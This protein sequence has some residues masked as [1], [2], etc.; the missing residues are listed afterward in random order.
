MRQLFLHANQSSRVEFVFVSDWMRSIAERDVGVKLRHY[1]V[2]PNFVNSE[3]FRYHPKPPELRRRVLLIRSFNTAKYANDW[4]VEAIHA[5]AHRYSGFAEMQFTIVGDG[6]LWTRLTSRLTYSNVS[7]IN[8]ML[9]RDEIK[10]LHDK[11]GVF[12]CPT[13]QDAQGVSMC[14]AMASG[15]VPVSSDNT[16]IP[17]FLSKEE[18]YLCKSPAEMAAALEELAEQKDV[19]ARKSRA[20]AVRAT[21]QIGMAA[22]ISREI[23]LIRRHLPDHGQQ[24][25]KG[26]VHSFSAAVH[27]SPEH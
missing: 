5:L 11:H 25:E 10:A 4:A 21:D 2:I 8:R 17:E 3:H 15:L 1:Q 7:L 18:G 24:A 27:D 6:I 23:E 20:A 9:D 13:R 16:A 22:T 14:E 26:A 19:F 12:L